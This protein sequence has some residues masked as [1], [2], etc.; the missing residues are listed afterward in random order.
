MKL[1]IKVYDLIVL[2]LW[3]IPIDLTNDDQI[4]KLFHIFNN[5]TRIDDSSENKTIK[6]KSEQKDKT[7]S[8]VNTKKDKSLNLKS[9]KKTD[10]NKIQ[11][12]TTETIDKLL[13]KKVQIGK[14]ATSTVYKVIN[15]ITNSGYL[16]LK[17]LKDEFFKKSNKEEEKKELSWNDDDDDNNDFEESDDKAEIDIDVI[18][19]LLQEYEILNLINHPNI[20]KVY[21]LYRGDLNHKP[22]ILLEYCKYNLEQVASKIEDIY[23]ISIIYEICSAMNYVHQRKLIHRDLSI[24]NI[25]INSAKHVKICDF[26]IAK[27]IDLTTLTSLT[28]GVGTIAFMAPEVLDKNTKYTEKVD[29]YSF[30]V[31]MYFILTKGQ[32]PEFSGVG[33]YIKLELPSII[34]KLSQQIIKA[35]WSR[36]PEKRPSFNKLLD[37]IVKKNFL[38]IDGI[39]EKVPSI[40]K[41]L[42]LI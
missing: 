2:F 19:Q 3:K 12:L 40:K 6:K 24:R 5:K 25:L 10:P 15:I 34:N 41:H 1:F 20:V 39:E 35:C 23:L 7:K 9:D 27:V 17:I 33:N 18:R 26:G 11:D 14:G 28:H 30:G 16:C 22:A 4:I 31:V 29:V 36:Q 21:G 8:S 42:G 32:M 13:I 38:L 37:T